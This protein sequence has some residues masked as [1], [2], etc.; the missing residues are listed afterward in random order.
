MLNRSRLFIT[1]AQLLG[2]ATSP[3]LAEVFRSVAL[4]CCRAASAGQ[5]V[6]IR[7]TALVT[8][9]AAPGAAGKKVTKRRLIGLHACAYAIIS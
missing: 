9:G 2:A 1:A 6:K 7:D 4:A 3:N 8:N 5:F